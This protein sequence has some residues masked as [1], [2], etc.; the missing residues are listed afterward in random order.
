MEGASGG[1]K[2]GGRWAVEGQDEQLWEAVLAPC[3]QRSKE[4]RVRRIDHG[5]DW[6][7]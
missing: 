2:R 3:A 6:E 1:V 5:V 4:V 7:K